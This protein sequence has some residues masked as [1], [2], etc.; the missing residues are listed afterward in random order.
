MADYT[1]SAKITGDSS[2]FE[3][4]FSTAQKAADRFETRMKSISSKLDSIGSSLSGFGAKLSL[5]ISTPIALAAK[6]MVNAASDFDEN[7]NKV[8]V[9]FG[10][11][12]EAVTSWAENATKQFGLS[13]NQALEATA[14]FGDMATSMGLAQPE[15]AN[16]STALAGLAGDLAS[17]KNIGVDQAMS[18][19]AGVFTGETESLKQL[20][21]VMTETNLEEF[22]SRTGKVYKEMSQAEKVQ[23]RYNYVMEMAANAQGDYA[24][25][26]DGTANSLRTFQGAV[27]N[28][29]I[30]LGQHLLPTLTPLVQKATEMVDAFANASPQVQQIALKIA[31]V[32]AVAGPALVIIGTL[33]SSIG[34][35][36][37]VIGMIGA[38]VTIAITAIAALAAGIVYLINTNETFR[39]M[40]AAIWDFVRDKIQSAIQAIRPVAETLF[41]GFI[42]G[43]KSFLP[44][45]QSMFSTIKTIVGVLS[46][47]LSGF[48]S[49]LSEGF[50]GSLSGIRGFGNVF[51]TV[52]GLIAPHIKMLL[53]LFQNF[54]SQIVSLVSTIGS[55][56]V[57]VFTTLGTTI[58]GIVSSLLPAFQSLMAN[59]APVIGDIVTVGS[60]LIGSVIDVLTMAL[61]IVVNLLNQV[62]PF[63]VQIASL[64]GNVVASVGPMIS[65]LSGALVPLLTSVINIIQTVLKVIMN[66]VTAAMPAVIAIM[67]V[68]MS[69][70]QAIVP[71]LT[72][73][74]SV[75]VSIVSV[76]ISVIASIISAISPI[77]SFIG[78]IISTIISVI[79]PIVTFVASI[80]ASIIS[81]IGKIIGAVSGVL[82]VIISTFSTAFSFVQN[83]FANISK[84]ISNAINVASSVIAT[85]AGTV[86]NVFN[87]VYSIVSSIMDKVGGYITGVFNGIKSAWNGLTSFVSGVFSG[88][89]SAVDALV[90]Q[91]KGFVNGV[92]GGINA[93]IGLIN[94]IPGVNIGT[95]P[96]L[97]HG[98]EDWQGGFARMNEGGRG[99]LTYLPNGT[100]VIPHDISM[101]YAKESAR[102][103]ANT[104]TTPI[105]YDRLIQGICEAMGNVTVQH[106][107][108]LNGKTV[109]SELLPLMDTGLG[110]KGVSRRRNSI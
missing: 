51:S 106:T 89:A 54:G 85:I 95:I 96:Y 36:A 45:F 57:P 55:S 82:D 69:V 68:V 84:V 2:G 3:K 91:V 9:A 65:Q 105:D 26:S 27:D 76:V 15:A 60:Q 72:N 7:L 78:G 103:N 8:D 93:A 86:G 20:G 90:S 32:A 67:N 18:A 49:G 16:M 4:A 39:N 44:A 19:L 14:L 75:V 74:I 35:I 92:I 77:V 108:T 83:I 21:I 41:Q 46:D 94:K 99:E 50:L 28:L 81:I 38:P 52:I 73:I 64:I 71:V 17:F 97:L 5:G 63:L 40:V 48:F 29:N 88:V 109:A 37:G 53:L 31:A 11:S 10:E 12:S 13:K 66:I 23:L 87:S 59:L 22:A 102:A 24:R 1:L 58:G 25:T 56:L 62:A 34:K 104:T 61:P 98:T 6:S 42:E 107:S 110:R 47:A 33:I 80:I 79:S 101:K 43:A 100:Q 70:I 30:A